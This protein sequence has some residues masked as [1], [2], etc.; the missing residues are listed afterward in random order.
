MIYKET[1]VCPDLLHPGEIEILQLQTYNGLPLQ[2][3]NKICFYFITIIMDCLVVTAVV[4]KFS[5]IIQFRS[6]HES[7]TKFKYYIST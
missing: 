7:F 6:I 3:R 4:F 2:K 1:F 5:G